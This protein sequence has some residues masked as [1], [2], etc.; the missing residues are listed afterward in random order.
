MTTES[1]KRSI[2]KLLHQLTT[3][4]YFNSI[5]LNMIFYIVEHETGSKIVQEDGTPWSGFLLGDN[6]WTNFTIAKRKYTLRLEWYKM[7][8]G[9]FEIN[10][11]VS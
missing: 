2:N 1:E 10:A 5:P 7:P 3:N 11:Y 9:R 6:S 8:S 4:Q